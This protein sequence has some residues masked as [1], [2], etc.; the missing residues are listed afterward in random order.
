MAEFTFCPYC[1]IPLKKNPDGFPACSRCGFIHWDNPVPVVA[2][3]I[4]MR[5]YWLK[6]AGIPTDGI[7]DGGLVIIQRGKQPFKDGF[8][9]P[10]GY[11]EKHGHPKAECVREALEETGLEVR[12]EKM[13]CACNP[14]PGEV[15]QIVISYLARPVGGRLRAGSDAKAVYVLSRSDRRQLCFRSH[16]MLREEYEAGNVGRLTGQDLLI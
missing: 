15:N 12:I 2:C 14:M 7:P 3:V 8:C 10:C 16:R 5:H 1:A 4:P 6:L 13:L 11:M 9:F